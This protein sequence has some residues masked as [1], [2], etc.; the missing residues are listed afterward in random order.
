M[1]QPPSGFI[2]KQSSGFRSLSCRGDTTS[3]TDANGISDQGIIVGRCD[4]KAFVLLPPYRNTDWITFSVG[5]PA[6]GAFR[7]P[8]GLELNK[9]VAYGINDE[10]RVVGNYTCENP[11]P[12]PATATRAAATHPDQSFAFAVNLEDLISGESER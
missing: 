12:P 2:W 11:T 8:A 4:S 7:C 5:D 6:M 3:D 1:Q 9:T 10:G